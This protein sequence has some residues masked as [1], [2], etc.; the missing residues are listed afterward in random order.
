[1]CWNDLTERL[2]WTTS[3]SIWKLDRFELD[4][5][6]V[7]PCLAA[8]EGSEGKMHPS[9][10][11]QAGGLLLSPHL[12]LREAAR[13]LPLS[14]KTSEAERGRSGPPSIAYNFWGWERPLGSS[15][16]RLQ[17][18]CQFYLK[19]P[20]V[21]G[22]CAF[23]I[24]AFFP[25]LVTCWKLIKLNF[26]V[27]RWYAEPNSYV[28]KAILKLCIGCLFFGYPHIQGKKSHWCTLLYRNIRFCFNL[29]NPTGVGVWFS[30]ISLI[31]WHKIWNKI[32]A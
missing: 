32:K 15:L 23:Q 6:R 17:L 14:P 5:E 8:V 2:K 25:L 7:H 19:H 9:P 22:F 30:S 24:T 21:L 1:M 27:Q 29:K 18:L 4:L 11:G 31:I 13:V 3:Y 12:R 28:A 16:Y 10:E 26:P 20:C